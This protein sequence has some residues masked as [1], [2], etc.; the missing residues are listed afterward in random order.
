MASGGFAGAAGG[1]AGSGGDTGGSGGTA[2]TGGGAP[3]VGPLPRGYLVYEGSG[4]ESPP[5]VYRAR[6]DENGIGEPLV[7][8]TNVPDGA[9]LG[10]GMRR[11]PGTSSLF[12]ALTGGGEDA[13]LLA[14]LHP[15]TTPDP[16]R[17]SDPIA[18]NENLL[19]FG[20]NEDGS[21]FYY[22]VETPGE[23]LDQLYLVDLEGE[24]PSSPEWI[25]GPV[26]AVGHVGWSGAV[27][28][29]R[30]IADND[31]AE[32]Y[33]VDASSWPPAAPERL[34][35]DANSEEG[36]VWAR[37]SPDGTRVV[38]NRELSGGEVFWYVLD[39]TLATPVPVPLVGTALDVAT[40]QFFWSPNSAHVVAELAEPSRLDL[41]GASPAGA[42]SLWTA[43][44]T[45]VLEQVFSPS[46]DRLM[47]SLRQIDSDDY[48]FVSDLAEGSHRGVPLSTTD[49][50]PRYAGNRAL[51]WFPDSRFVAFALQDGTG[52]YVGD[53][54]D[55]GAAPRSIAEGAVGVTSF[56]VSP[57]GGHV[58]FAAESEVGQIDVF[59]V[60]VDVEARPGA[61]RRVSADNALPFARVYSD[62][63]FLDA[64][65]L[66]FTE[67]EEDGPVRL[68]IA[69][70][71]GSVDAIEVGD[72]TLDKSSLI[73]I[74]D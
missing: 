19:H 17:L 22:V 41:E 11:I 52:P 48:I 53:F 58:A 12:Y 69:P 2:G 47:F 26:D 20:P 29:Y 9:A 67:Y 28:Y 59:V 49:L 30:E 54:E 32:L 66:L 35:T 21:R 71:D 5:Q 55:P 7:V 16:V 25:T 51:Q 1:A 18:S 43:E 3:S 33:R 44:S 70:V 73:W 39:T 31:D 23:S 56:E 65:W 27:Y 74:P 10:A 68:F 6:T 4:P 15:T 14:K 24:T 72:P 37:L 13:L 62:P 34:S 40:S 36:E 8:S 60:P 64:E 42:T 57:Y 45:D 38:Y 63:G 46:G 61:V 50:T